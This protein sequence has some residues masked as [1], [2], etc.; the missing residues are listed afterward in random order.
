MVMS[1]PS[2]EE[3]IRER[4]R[5]VG[6]NYL[7][8]KKTQETKYNYVMVGSALTPISTLRVEASR[9]LR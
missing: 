3:I 7:L 4:E 5:I 2:R 6:K 8:K 1:R 9:T